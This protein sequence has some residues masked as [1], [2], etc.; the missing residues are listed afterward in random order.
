MEKKDSYNRRHYNSW[1]HTTHTQTHTY[2]HDIYKSQLTP[3]ISLILLL[4]GKK[5]LWSC[6][7][8][9]FFHIQNRL[10]QIYWQEKKKIS[11]GVSES[12]FKT[13]T[14]IPHTRLTVSTMNNSDSSIRRQ[15]SQKV[16]KSLKRHFFFCWS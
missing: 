5:S 4:L 2:N 11:Y 1:L 16:D 8:H 10:L 13:C 9:I 15:C 14:H 7:R 12:I 3:I 6:D